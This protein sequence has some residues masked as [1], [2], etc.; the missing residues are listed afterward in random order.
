VKTIGQGLATA[1]LLA[2]GN[3]AD[4][5]GVEWG[6]SHSDPR[7]AVEYALTLPAGSPRDEALRRLI[8]YWDSIGLGEPASRNPPLG[9]S[10][11][12][13]FDSPAVTQVFTLWE[14]LRDDASY[15]TSAADLDRLL[16]DLSA[17]NFLA[18]DFQDQVLF[19]TLRKEFAIQFAQLHSVSEPH[20]S[21]LLA[22]GVAALA[23]TGSQKGGR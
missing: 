12:P 5:Q 17:A 9:I 10:L 14:P 21:W 11:L 20:G 18:Q 1:L 22:A 23:G 3:A 6:W 7:P 19:P 15:L 2:F 4:S 16:G 13:V 8:S